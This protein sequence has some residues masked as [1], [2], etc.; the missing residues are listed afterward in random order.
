[1]DTATDSQPFQMAEPIPGYRVQERIG[2]GGYGEVWKADAPGGIAKAIKIVFGYHDDERA[3]RELNALNRIKQVRHPFLLSLERIELVDGRLV[4]VTELATSSL[5]NLFDQYRQSGLTGVPRGE[6]LTLLGDAADALD[7][8]SQVHSLQHLDIKP[9]NLLLVGGRTKVAD[10][11]LVKDLQDV[12]CSIVGGLTPLYAAPE[13]FDGRPNAHS[14]QYSLAIVYQ[15]ML[16]GVPPFEGRTMAQLAAQHLHSRPHLDALPLADQETIAR[17]LSKD[18]SQ[19]FPSC[20]EMINS[21]A[22]R[23]SAPCRRREPSQNLAVTIPPC[24]HRSKPRCS[25]KKASAGSRCRGGAASSMTQPTE[26]APRVRDLPRLELPAEAAAYR[27]TIFVGMGGLAAKTLQTLHRHL[28]NRFG[29]LSAVP[30]LQFLFLETDAETL[31]TVTEADLQTPLSNDSAIFLPLR[32]AA[33]YRR[34]SGNHLQ[35][36]SRRWIYN[37]PR[38]AQTQSFRPLGRLAFVD[39]LDRVLERLSQTIKAAVDRGALATSAQST[40]LPFQEAPPRVFLVSSISGGTGSGMV[41]DVAYAVR[42]VLRDLGLSEEG[43]CGILAHCSGHNPQGRDLAVANAYAFLTELHH[44]SDPHNAYPGDPSRGL[45]AFAAADAPFSQTYV[46]NLDED[47]EP[48][49]FAAAADKLAKYLY[50]NAVT[51]A[52]AYFDACRSGPTPDEPSAAADPG[53]R[54]FG[55]AQLGFSY[56]AIP[57]TVVDELCQALVTRWRGIDDEKSD[58]TPASLADPTTLLANRFT[59]GLSPEELRAKVAS[60]MKALE[61]DIQPIVAQLSATTTREMGNAPESYLLTVLAD[62]VN[63]HESTRGCSNPLPLSET[64]LDALDA[65]ISFQSIQDTRRVCLEAVLET[66]L[67]EMAASQAAA[68]REWILSLVNS[69][70]YR[71]VGAQQAAD[72]VTEYLRALS[73]EASESVKTS[74]RQ[75]SALKQTLLSDKNG[76]RGWLQYR[77]FAWKRRLVAD[78]RLCQYFRL[79]IDELTL[80]GVCRLSG[81]MLAQMS[82]LADHLRNLSADL[83]RLAKEFGAQ[84]AGALSARRPTPWR[85]FGRWPKRSVPT[86]WSWSRRWNA[87]WN[88][89][90]TAWPRRRETT[91]SARWL[92]FCVARRDPCFIVC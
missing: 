20:R 82:A 62:L 47:L 10:F 18:P 83:N 66:H 76:G 84:P 36:L 85:C 71:M 49:E 33:D 48:E 89:S 3:T 23:R 52:G 72:Y 11:G 16:T 42:K 4:I 9:E 26:P 50:Y 46:V 53:L 32:Q 60:R 2:A 13:L 19:R 43:V 27:P 37:I 1:M 12:N 51:A 31:K 65:L 30:A 40:G 58:Q 73:R 70:K 78:R 61:L 35:W 64:I 39:H 92:P 90:C 14:D 74:G 17:A 25:R 15:E 55:L 81:F 86:R 59:T 91:F 24:P 57:A 75:L 38:S 88:P 29:P 56:D 6:L 77:G 22:P 80:N 21:L 7:Y 54:T 69:P 44:Y 67:K 41:I 5:K 45:P 8:I 87:I 34:E 28:V 63:N 79:K 68:L